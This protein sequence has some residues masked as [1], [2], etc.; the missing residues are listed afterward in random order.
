MVRLTTPLFILKNDALQ[1]LLKRGR[2]APPP[3][4][5]AR[6]LGVRIKWGLR[7]RACL[8]CCTR[9]PHGR[10]LGGRGLRPQG[11]PGRRGRACIRPTRSLAAP[12]PRSPKQGGPVLPSTGLLSC[13]GPEHAASVQYSIQARPGCRLSCPWLAALAAARVLLLVLTCICRKSPL[14]LC[15]YSPAGSA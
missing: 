12:R 4:L 5:A 9:K 15:P 6:T 11:L 8:G 3:F 13:A 10:E 1:L 7:E 2:T 14:L